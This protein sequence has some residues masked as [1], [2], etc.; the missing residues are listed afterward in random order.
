MDAVS[1]PNDKVVEFITAN[2]VPLRS[3]FDSPLAAEFRV[4][5]TPTLVVADEQGEEHHR[6][7]G[8]LPP[9]ELVAQ[10]M[11][12]IGKAHFDA[13]RFDRAIGA[14]DDLVACCRQ[15]KAAPEALYLRGV[16]RY[17]S[18][19]DPEQLRK[20]HEELEESYPD[21]EWEQRAKAYDLL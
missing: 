5:W 3:R 14:F 8:Y 12:G 19:H 15:S 20:T 2:I 16:S 1:Y 9:D 7:V 21:S 18:S 6:T 13:D 11:L 4:K 17:K 10:L